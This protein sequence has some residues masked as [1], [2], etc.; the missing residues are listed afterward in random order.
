M[1]AENEGWKVP[2]NPTFLSGPTK[3]FFYLLIDRCGTYLPTYLLPSYLPTFLPTYLLPSYLPTYFL[4]T[5]L[6]TYLLPSYLPTYL[7]ASF[8]PTYLL[9]SYL[10]TYLPYYLLASFNSSRFFSHDP[11]SY[12]NFSSHY[13]GRW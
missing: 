5:Y 2:T 6:P 8:L 11:L 3:S 9:A 7:L 13:L 1:S 4:P 10:P 12:L